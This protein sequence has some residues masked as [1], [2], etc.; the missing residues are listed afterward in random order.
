MRTVPVISATVLR[1]LPAMVRNE[2]GDRALARVQTVARVDLEVLEKEDCFVPHSAV[3]DFLEASARASGDGLFGL[4]LVPHMSVS[5]YGCW[6]AYLLSA[7]TLGEALTR[8]IEHFG[9]HSAGDK[10]WLTVRGD[11]ARLSYAFA[12]AGG[13][14]YAHVCPV[15]AKVL[16]S[17][18]AP[19]VFRGWRP[20]RVELD[21]PR[22]QRTETFEDAF[23]C[24]VRF[25]APAV[26]VVM[27][28]AC[29][30]FPAREQHPVVT[31]EDVARA[32][33]GSAPR[34]P[35]GAISE[36][37]RVQLLSRN[38]SIET[39]ARALATS[40]RTL[41]REL[42]RAGTDFRSLVNAARSDRAKELLRHGDT[43]ITGIST[44]LGY[45]A[46]AHFSRAF[47]RETGSRPRD[48][49]S[50]A[51]RALGKPAVPAGLPHDP[52]ARH[53]DSHRARPRPH[54]CEPD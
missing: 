6:G 11:E 35:F 36:Q 16:I 23:G 13:A 9:Y 22:P 38:V 10:V 25:D 5:N 29:L 4:A 51:L 1:G 12:L 54:C 31:I 30:A 21:I 44:D 19:Y 47:L 43:T 48:Y 53:G 50:R 33:R 28:R 34:D 18:C 45:S 15:A 8:T 24:P 42:N 37:V 49:R 32:R 17:L 3:V 39:T 20:R 27:D 14:G 26:T 52:A 7:G 2:I 46:P 40:V 41:Q